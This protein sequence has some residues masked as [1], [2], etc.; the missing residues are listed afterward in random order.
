MLNGIHNFNKVPLA[1]PGIKIVVHNK[2]SQRNSW[3]YHDT[4]GWYTGPAFE[5]YRY[6]KCYLPI[7]RAEIVSDTVCLLPTRL[8]IPEANIDDYI[9]ASVQELILLISSQQSNI[10][11]LKSNIAKTVLKSL[12]N[13]LETKKTNVHQLEQ[14]QNNKNNNNPKQLSLPSCVTSEGGTSIKK[15]VKIN[16]LSDEEFDALLKSIPQQV[17]TNAKSQVK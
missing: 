11:G 17:G 6:L 5:H 14:T 7:T 1:L 9:R 3:Q 8:A 13:T 2:P 10:P 15:H 12:T 4:E 16:P